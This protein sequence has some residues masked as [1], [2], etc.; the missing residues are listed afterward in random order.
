MVQVPSFNSKVVAAAQRIRQFMINGKQAS[1][2]IVPTSSFLILGDSHLS[3]LHDEIP[4]CSTVAI[5]GGKIRHGIEYV[6]RADLSSYQAVIVLVG[7]NDAAEIDIWKV[8][9][10]IGRL[11]NEIHS[12]RPNI[13]I[14]TASFVPRVARKVD[15]IRNCCVYDGVIEKRVKGHHHAVFPQ[16]FL[17]R[18]FSGNSQLNDEYYQ[19]DETHLNAVGREVLIGALKAIVD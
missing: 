13:A 12:K 5:R 11:I 7:G 17:K 6:I 16:V 2:R 10:N 19:R 8:E 14:I 4:N 18:T 15:F 9:E 3:F 1:E